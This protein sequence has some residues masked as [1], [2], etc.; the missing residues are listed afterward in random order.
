MK[1]KDRDCSDRLPD[2][3]VAKKRW[4][5]MAGVMET[6]PDKPTVSSELKE[7]FHSD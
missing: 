4:S 5:C 7:V 3:P 1:P 2:N 6:D